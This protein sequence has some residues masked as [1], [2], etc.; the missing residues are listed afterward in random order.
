MAWH[1]TV[2]IPVQCVCGQR[3]CYTCQDAARGD[4]APAS[5]ADTDAWM[6]KFKSEA[7]NM[8]WMKVHW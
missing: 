5:C 4:H 8:M 1:S 6:S 7:D 3:F 2:N